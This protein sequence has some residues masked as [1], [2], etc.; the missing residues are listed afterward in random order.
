[1][2]CRVEW[3]V[4]YHSNPNHSLIQEKY[5]YSRKDNVIP[6]TLEGLRWIQKEISKFGGDPSQVTILG[7]SSSAGLITQV[8]LSPQSIGLF[9]RLIAI[10]GTVFELPLQNFDEVNRQMALRVGC[11]KKSTWKAEN[12]KLVLTSEDMARK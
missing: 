1:M 8:S 5:N 6:D 9:H 3:G 7:Y 12:F 4:T 11:A 2:K 10:S